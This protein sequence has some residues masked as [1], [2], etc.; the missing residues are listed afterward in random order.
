MR[1]TVNCYLKEMREEI[2]QMREEKECGV[3]EKEEHEHYVYRFKR[4][5][6]HIDRMDGTVE[7]LVALNKGYK[8]F[9]KEYEAD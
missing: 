2:I 5:I 4:D 9:L 7:E 6:R 8:E 1:G 3:F